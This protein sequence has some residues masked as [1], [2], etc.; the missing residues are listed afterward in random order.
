LRRLR[1]F[2]EASHAPPTLA[3]TLT[4]AVF[5]WG[6]GWRSWPLA[7]VGAAIFIG[8][9]SVGWSNDAFDASTDARADRQSK[10]TVRRDISPR[11]LW[12]AAAT[13]LTVACI[14]SWYAAGWVGGSF[15]VFALLMAWTYNLA[16][17]R[18]AWSW[19]P[20][21]LAFGSLPVFLYVGLDG[22]MGPWWTVIVFAIIAVSAHIAN[23]LPDMESDTASG[24]DGFVI[25]LGERRSTLL[26]WLLLGSGTAILV[27]VAA[28]S[29]SAPWTPIAL[30]IAFV[31]AVLYGT[32]SARRSSTFLALLAVVVIDVVALISSPAL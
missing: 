11:A 29:A 4:T 25:R 2:A 12:I 3:V 1:A 15:H 6:I 24:L 16:L 9:L 30:L 22:Q 8:Q 31:G 26:C 23:A 21:A 18:T 32:F 19:L 13:A 14:L 7:I 20:Y 27:V 10:P 28:T 5:A 17:S